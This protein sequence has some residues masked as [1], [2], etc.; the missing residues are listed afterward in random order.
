MRSLTLGPW[1]IWIW[2]SKYNFLD[3]LIGI[4]RSSHDNALQWMPQDLN[5][6]KSTLVVQVMTWCRQAPSQ[7]LSQCQPRSMSS[8]IVTRPQW[9]N[10]LVGSYMFILHTMVILYRPNA[11][12]LDKCNQQFPL[13]RFLAL[14]LVDHA[15]TIYLHNDAMSPSTVILRPIVANYLHTQGPNKHVSSI[16]H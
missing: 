6:D 7:Y 13:V 1:E 2:S 9:V 14:H 16:M 11:L 3:L 12:Y 15:T 5:D 8:N 4:F 10:I